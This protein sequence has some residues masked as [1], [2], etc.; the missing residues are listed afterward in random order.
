M[1]AS[2]RV[3]ALRP[4]ATR[5]PSD[6][7]GFAPRP[8]AGPLGG[9]AHRQGLVGIRSALAGRGPYRAHCALGPVGPRGPLRLRRLPWLGWASARSV[10]AWRSRLGIWRSWLRGLPTTGGRGSIATGRRAPERSTCPA[11]QT[12]DH[13]VDCTL[14]PAFFLA[15]RKLDGYPAGEP[16]TLGP[17]ARPLDLAEAV[18]IRSGRRVLTGVV[19][20]AGPDGAG[21]HLA[22]PPGRRLRR[23]R[24]SELPAPVVPRVELAAGTGARSTSGLGRSRPA[25]FEPPRR[26]RSASRAPVATRS[27]W[28][29]VGAASPACDTPLT[30]GRSTRELGP[31]ARSSAGRSPPTASRQRRGSDDA[32]ARRRPGVRRLE[33]RLRLRRTSARATVDAFEPGDEPGWEGDGVAPGREV[34]LLGGQLRAR[35]RRRGRG[36]GATAVTGQSW[37]LIVNRTAPVRGSRTRVWRSLRS[38]TLVDA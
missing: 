1:L 34:G 29:I 4:G 31:A 27:G 5:R 35:A 20:A 21:D 17:D 8:R 33:R 10:G 30:T 15:S 22:A 6:R 26:G 19:A 38:Q 18:E 13:A 24:R 2:C 16:F 28:P 23:P 3:A 9:R 7:R 14:A 12:A 11:L 32:S 37:V 36:A 25:R